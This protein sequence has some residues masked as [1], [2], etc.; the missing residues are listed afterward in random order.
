MS[1]EL[2]SV[3]FSHSLSFYR[4]VTWIHSLWWEV[5][6][7]LITSQNRCLRLLSVACLG[8]EEDETEAV[9]AGFITPLGSPPACELVTFLDNLCLAADRCEEVAMML[10]SAVL[11]SEAFL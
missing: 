1:S 7:F 10:T 8:V 2:P 3:L 6:C 11:V 9:A 4:P 5:K